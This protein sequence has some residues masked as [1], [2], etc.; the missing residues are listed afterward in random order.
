MLCGLKG[1]LIVNILDVASSF[2]SCEFVHVIREANTLTHNIA[3]LEGSVEGYYVWEGSL[4]P[5]IQL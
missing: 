4:P 5:D 3:K 2:D 1:Y